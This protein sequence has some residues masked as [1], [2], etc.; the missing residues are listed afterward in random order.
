MKSKL[1]SYL[2]SF[3]LVSLQGYFCPAYEDLGLNVRWLSDTVEPERGPDLERAR[4][5]MVSRIIVSGT[6]LIADTSS[7]PFH[8]FTDHRRRQYY[9]HELPLH[10]TNIHNHFPG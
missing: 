5:L 7:V 3:T 2:N 6:M 9:S 8:S 4:E 1:L 10:M